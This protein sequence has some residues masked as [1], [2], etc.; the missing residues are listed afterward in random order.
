MI[1]EGLILKKVTLDEM[2][3]HPDKEYNPSVWL[4]KM[5]NYPKCQ[6]YL[7]PPDDIYSYTRF[8]VSYIADGIYFFSNFSAYSGTLTNNGFC[9]VYIAQ[10]GQV[11]KHLFRNDKGEEGYADNVEHNRKCFRELLTPRGI[12]VSNCI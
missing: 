4:E 2:L 6:F 12:M 7:I 10:D 9:K 1:K 5:S 3:A 11:W 8:Y